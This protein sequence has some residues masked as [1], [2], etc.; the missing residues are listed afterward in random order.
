MSFFTQTISSRS[1][2]SSVL[3]NPPELPVVRP[4]I[5]SSVISFE[6]DKVYRLKCQINSVEI[7]LKE[8]G[9][10][11]P[12]CLKFCPGIEFCGRDDVSLV[13]SCV[14]LCYDELNESLTT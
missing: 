7:D 5:V 8:L 10:Q 9:D 11:L 12:K 1:L 14:Y 2:T 3:I 13:S 6:S 4:K